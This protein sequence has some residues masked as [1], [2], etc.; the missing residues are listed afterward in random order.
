[1][2]HAIVMAGGSGTRFWPASRAS[3]P[4]QL[5]PLAGPTTL[6]EDTVTRLDGLVHP[7][8]TMIVTS[9]RLLDAVRRQAARVPATGIVGEPCKRDTAPCIGLAALLVSRHDPDATMA[10]M[11]SDHV[12]HPAADFRRAILQAAAMVEAAPGRLVT[13]GV[14]PT[15]PA[16]SFGYIQQGAALPLGPGEAPAHAVA[17][18]REKPPARVAAEYLAAGTYLWN[19]GIFVWKASTIIA[20]LDERQPDSMA[21]LRRIAA[22]WETPDR[23]RVFA[24]EFAAIKGISIDYAVLEHATDVAVIEA[25]FGWDDLGGWSAVARHLAAD[26]QGNTAVGRHLT[27]DSTNTV[28]HTSD[29]HLVVTLGLVDILVVHT[30]DATLVAHRSHEEAIRKVVAELEKCGWNEYL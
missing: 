22:S 7:D 23:D 1:M 5:L 19:A 10:V 30:P 27:I 21:H 15:Y 20:A 28:V 6:L 17:R 12:I 8:Q 3:L 16:E 9:A 24:E 29:D 2:L 25:P 13:F 18:F 14:R 26:A 11:P 4:K